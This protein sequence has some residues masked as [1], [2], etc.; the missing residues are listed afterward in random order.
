MSRSRR[1]LVAQ[2]QLPAQRLSRRHLAGR[3]T[4]GL[5]RRGVRMDISGEVGFMLPLAVLMSLVLLLGSLSVQGVALQRHMSDS[6]SLKSRTKEDALA[7]SAQ[8][9]AG[10]L[11]LSGN[12]LIKKD[13]RKWDDEKCYVTK[14]PYL[15]GSIS[16][17]TYQVIDYKYSQNDSDTQSSSA[18]LTL[19]WNPGP[20]SKDTLKTFTLS[21]DS[22]VDPPRL[23]G[24]TP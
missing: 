9:V 24:V 23:L 19:S 2:S 16:G 7:S 11:Q 3:P 4:C 22:S 12:C 21:I 17:G 14:S 5:G 10:A 8:V 20:N 1:R 15:T 6:I 13:Y 18:D